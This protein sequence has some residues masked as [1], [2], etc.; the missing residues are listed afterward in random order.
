MNPRSRAAIA[1]PL[2]LCVVA[3]CQSSGVD[4]PPGWD[5]LKPCSYSHPIAVEDLADIGKPG[6]N[7]AGTTVTFPDGRTAK[8]GSVGVTDSW[9]YL[10]TGEAGTIP[11][12]FTMVNWGVPGVAVSGYNTHG[13]V[14]KVWAMSKDAAALQRALD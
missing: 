14:T 11:K 3:A 1:A 10:V 4:V 6:C 12:H 5:D 7:M 13:K 9:G 2:L 8:V